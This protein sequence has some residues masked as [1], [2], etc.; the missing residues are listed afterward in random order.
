MTKKQNPILRILFTIIIFAGLGAGGTYVYLMMQENGIFPISQ[1]NKLKVNYNELEKIENDMGLMETY[2]DGAPYTGFAVTAKLT[3]E[4]GIN[5]YMVQE[6]SE[7]GIMNGGN[8]SYI[9]EDNQPT[10]FNF[11]KVKDTENYITN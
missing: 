3:L 2:Y 7:G 4:S 1:T 5:V 11:S 8:S 6:Y 9:N 10:Q